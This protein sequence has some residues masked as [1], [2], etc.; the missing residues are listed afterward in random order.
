MIIFGKIENFG[1]SPAGRTHRVVVDVDVFLV[2]GTNDRFILAFDDGTVPRILGVILLQT[3][4]FTPSQW[5]GR[6]LIRWERCRQREPL[7]TVA[8]RKP[9]II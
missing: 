1:D 8:M 6:K 7:I 3:Q 9:V 4:I 5:G 2:A